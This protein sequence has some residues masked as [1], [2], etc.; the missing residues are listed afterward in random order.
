MADHW[1]KGSDVAMP[2]IRI[3]K[4]LPKVYENAAVLGP[5][6]ISCR[7]FATWPHWSEDSC[8]QTVRLLVVPHSRFIDPPVRMKMSCLIGLSVLNA[9]LGYIVQHILYRDTTRKSYNLKQLCSVSVLSTISA[10]HSSPHK[11]LIQQTS[12]SFVLKRVSTLLI[13]TYIQAKIG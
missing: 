11:R 2:Q 7:G 10:Q 13:V 12:L 6:V 9:S 5:P 3:A 4:E 8:R 1:I